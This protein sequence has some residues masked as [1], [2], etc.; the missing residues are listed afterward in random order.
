MASSGEGYCQ[1]SHCHLAL[2]VLEGESFVKI[3]L[4]DIGLSDYSKPEMHPLMRNRS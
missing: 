2:S 4:Q 1:T 3:F